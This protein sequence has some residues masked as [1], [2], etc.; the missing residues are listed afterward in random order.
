MEFTAFTSAA[1]TEC[2][3]VRRPDSPPSKL[4]RLRAIF[5]KQET[6]TTRGRRNSRCTNGF[7]A[8]RNHQ[9]FRGAIGPGQEDKRGQDDRHG[10]EA[11]IETTAESVDPLGQISPFRAH[12]Q[13][14]SPS[15]SDHRPVTLEHSMTAPVASKATATMRL[16]L[17]EGT[18]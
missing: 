8:L 6:G 9:G 14:S 10:Y 5:K 16:R 15:G 13:I 1:A 11:I 3:T 7:K 12:G 18:C 2:E 17:F 4:M